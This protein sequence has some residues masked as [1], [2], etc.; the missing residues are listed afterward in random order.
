MTT[1]NN[2]ASLG[3]SPAFSAYQSSSQSVT[4]GNWTQIN[5]QTK[6][7]DTASAFDNVTNYRFN[8]QVAGY[9]QTSG[10]VGMN[11]SATTIQLA[12]YKNATLAKY[13]EISN[14][15]TE[16]NV[17]GSTLIYLNGT[18]DFLTLVVNIGTSQGLAANS[19]STFF[20]AVLVRAA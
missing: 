5:F 20:Q 13:L 12:V 7:F 14:S 17:S 3:N 11:A 16:S 18:N 19:A 15:S 1:A 8:P 2:L 4:A 9:Y 10:G 6:E